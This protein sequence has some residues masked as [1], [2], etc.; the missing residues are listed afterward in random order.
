MLTIKDLKV[1][2]YTPFGTTE[3]VRGVDLEIKE[4][5]LTALVGESGSGKTVTAFS[6]LRLIDPPGKIE[7]GEI[8]WQ[9][10]NLLT[11]PENELRKIRGKE[12]AMI[13]QDPFNSLNPVYTIGEQISE[14][15]Q[16]HQ[17]LDKS[18]AWA[19]TIKILTAVHLAEPEKKA[20]SYPHQ[21]SGGMC[22]RVMIAMAL[23]CRPKL[24][25]ADEPTTALDVTIQ[26][27]ILELLKEVQKNFKTSIL[28]ITHN[29]A[30]VSNYCEQVYVM[31]EGRIIE[32]GNTKK[33]FADPQDHYTKKLLNSVPSI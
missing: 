29:L 14:I 10:K 18:K 23:S 1:N 12:I 7:S 20:R 2:F 8:L 31:R 19:E 13:F 6:I 28:L 17:G 15:I 4:N 32:Q 33:V 9:D 24:I 5:E 27:E 26:A 16:L 25:I 11:M 22:Q 21:L 3:A 30:I